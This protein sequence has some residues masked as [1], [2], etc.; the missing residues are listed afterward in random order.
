MAAFRS[1]RVARGVTELFVARGVL[2]EAVGLSKLAGRNA[3]ILERQELEI[4]RG[5]CGG[6]E[7]KREMRSED[8]SASWSLGDSVA[9]YRWKALALGTVRSLRG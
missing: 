8:R 6:L 7:L 5:H 4:A 2:V 3:D 9:M 1:K